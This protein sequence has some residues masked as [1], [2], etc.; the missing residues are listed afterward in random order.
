MP[1]TEARKHTEMPLPSL[2]VAESAADT[3]GTKEEAVVS[4]KQTFYI[5]LP[6]AF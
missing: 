6:T 1:W 4:V 3:L 2:Q 5:M